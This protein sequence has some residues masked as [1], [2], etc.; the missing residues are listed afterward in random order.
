MEYLRGKH[1]NSHKRTEKA[2]RKTSESLCKKHK[3][4][5]WGWGVKPVWNKGLIGYRQ[6][7]PRHTYNEKFK[8]KISEIT[9][10][11]M[12]NPEVRKLLRERTLELIK[13]GRMPKKDSKLEKK[14]EQ[15]ISDANL[16]YIKQWK[17][18]LGIADFFLPEKNIV[19]E[20]DG[21]YWHSLPKRIERDK[22]HTEFLISR[23]YNVVRI[24]ESEI[25]NDIENIE[26][27]IKSWR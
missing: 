13:S 3:E 16:S 17:Y 12:E 7:I 10:K 11:R 25:N 1:P 6:G 5:K 9:K 2:N 27:I 22:I 4:M 26:K 14:I 15:I 18:D 21:T 20:V 8:K 24:S 19:L 23:G